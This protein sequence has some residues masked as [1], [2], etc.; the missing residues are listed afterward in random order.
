MHN[1]GKT[2]YYG[3]SEN[4]FFCCVFFATELTLGFGGLPTVLSWCYGW[5]STLGHWSPHASLKLIKAQTGIISLTDT[6]DSWHQCWLIARNTDLIWCDFVC[7]LFKQPVVTAGSTIWIH[8]KNYNINNQYL[9][10]NSPQPGGSGP[11]GSFSADIM[12]AWKRGMHT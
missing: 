7:D 12:D 6:M 9:I 10:I 3:I 4:C 8:S 11:R 2:N 5:Q 1:L